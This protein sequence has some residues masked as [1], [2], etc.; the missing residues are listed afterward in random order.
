MRISDWSSDVCSSD[1]SQARG[2]GQ[3]GG[4]KGHDLASTQ[5]RC[6]AWRQNRGTQKDKPRPSLAGRVKI[7]PT[8]QGKSCRLIRSWL[9]FMR[10]SPAFVQIGRASCRERVCQYV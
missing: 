4:V 8:L 2:V 3:A 9:A 5:G 6:Q 10:W 1:L 7:Q